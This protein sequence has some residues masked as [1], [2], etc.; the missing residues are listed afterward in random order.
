MDGELSIEEL[1]A[2]VDVPVRTVRYYIAEGLL[3][4]PG[5]R[6]RA[7]AYG[8]EHLL[9]LRLIRRLVEQRVPLAEIRQ[10]LGSL[11]LAEV[12]ALLVEE[13]RHSARLQ[14][15]AA[16]PSPRD[17]VAALLARAGSPS[18][19]APL[20]PPAKGRVLR[21]AGPSWT[22]S[23]PWTRWEL[24][25]G[26]ELHVRADASEDQRRLVQRLLQAAQDGRG[27]RDRAGEEPEPSPEE[28]DE[29]PRGRGGGPRYRAGPDSGGAAPT[30]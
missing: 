13:E 6:G 30:P 21:E 18:P 28:E 24:A 1:A 12:A 25:P 15:A 11:A 10:R 14:R 2:R 3:P 19:P 22:P 7:A 26:V 9:R 16:G 29:R 8:E 17:Y 23:R 20:P 27:G 5:A 4:G